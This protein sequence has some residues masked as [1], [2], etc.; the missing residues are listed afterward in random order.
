[1]AHFNTGHT[2]AFE[3]N[4][5]I[6]TKGDRNWQQYFLKPSIGI[7][8]GYINLA[9][10]QYLGNGYSIF[11]FVDFP[12]NKAD[13]VKLRL[14]FGYGLGFVEKNFDRTD[15]YKNLAL[16][17]KLNV[18]IGINQKAEI[19]IA[20]NFKTSIGFSF[21]HFSNGA[22][23]TPNLGINI[24]ALNIGVKYGFN[25]IDAVNFTAVDREKKWN[26]LLLLNFGAKEIAPFNG[27]KYPIASIV[28]EK[29]KVVSNKSDLG[30]GLDVF[31]NASLPVLIERDTNLTSG[32][33]DAIR[34]GVHGAWFLNLG[35]LQYYFNFGGY[36]INHYRDRGM[37]FHRIGS[38]YALNDKFILNLSLK[39]HFAVADFVEF[40]IAYKIK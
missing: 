7:G 21:W 27:P 30:V 16:G 19:K 34:L 9:N 24:P 37:F 2:K 22:F 26:T 38:R 35:K 13:R 10:K 18:F 33:F 5:H 8:F 25:K 40:G 20:D 1:M 23:K 17:S 31:Y 14:Q 11:P 36:F 4:Y 12:L 39:T 32:N 15:N 3:L 28:F 29:T 6:Q